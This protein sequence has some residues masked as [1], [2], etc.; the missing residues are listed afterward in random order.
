MFSVSD[1]LIDKEEVALALSLPIQIPDDPD[2]VSEPDIAEQISISDET[3]SVPKPVLHYVI[4]KLANL[5]QTQGL[6]CCQCKRARYQLSRLSDSGGRLNS[7]YSLEI[8]CPYG[9]TAYRFELSLS[10]KEDPPTLFTQIPTVN[11]KGGY[12]HA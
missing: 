3:D 10:P 4:E 8:I 12:A 9:N 11:L 6:P 2:S 1:V 5:L 7:I